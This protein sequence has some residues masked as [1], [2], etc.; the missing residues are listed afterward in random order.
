MKNIWRA[1]KVL[2]KKIEYMNGSLDIL[3]YCRHCKI[4]CITTEKGVICPTCGRFIQDER[5]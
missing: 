1:W 3:I 2:K 5:L 4:E